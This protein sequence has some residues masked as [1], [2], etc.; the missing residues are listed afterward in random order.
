MAQ[1]V[2][3]GNSRGIRIPKALIEQAGLENRELELKVLE[4]GLLVLPVR[5]GRQGWEAAFRSMRSAGDDELLMG[6]ARTEFDEHEW[7]W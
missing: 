3:I 2:Q 1:L 6:D 4:E 7:E 5:V